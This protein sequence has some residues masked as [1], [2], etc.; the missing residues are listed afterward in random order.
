MAGFARERAGS[1][2]ELEP[3]RRELLAL[4]AA[5]AA[6]HRR[7]LLAALGAPDPAGPAG[8]AVA[9]LAAAGREALCRRARAILDA[10]AAIQGYASPELVCRVLA[11][12]LAAAGGSN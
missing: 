2:R 10:V 7:A 11:G 5:A 4:F 3:V 8:G 12:E 6:L 9:A 1:A